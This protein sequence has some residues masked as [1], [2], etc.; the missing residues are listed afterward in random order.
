MIG[1]P[2]FIYKIEDDD[3][4]K[5]EEGHGAEAFFGAPF[6]FEIFLENGEGL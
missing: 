2:G 5:C 6:G 4:Q 1:D 3:D